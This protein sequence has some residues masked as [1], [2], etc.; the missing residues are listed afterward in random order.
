MK[1]SDVC[2]EYGLLNLREGVVRI[3]FLVKGAL[4]VPPEISL[5]KVRE[6][7]Q[8]VD[9]GTGY[10]KVPGAQIVREPLIDRQTM[11]YSG[12]YLYQVMPGISAPAL[13]ETD[14]DKLANGLYNLKVV[15]ILQYLATIISPLVEETEPVSR[16]WEIYRLTSE[17]PDTFL[18]GWQHS[19]FHLSAPQ[20]A[21]QMIDRE[22]SLGGITGGAFLDGWVDISAQVLPGETALLSPRTVANYTSHRPVI[23][24]MPTRQLHI[25]AGNAPEV[26]LASLLRALLTKSAAVIKLPFGAIIPGALFS[27]AAAAAAPGHPLTQNLSLVY[28][29]GGDRTIEDGLFHRDSFDRIVVWGSPEAV[30][31]VQSRALFTR[32]VVFN[33]RY[34]VSLIGRPASDDDLAEVVLKAAVD[35]LIYDQKACT[36]SLVH[37]VEGDLTRVRDYAVRM[38]Q[39]LALWDEHHPHFITPLKL[40]QIRSLKRGKYLNA[41]WYLNEKEGR[42]TSGV[43]V[44]DGEFDLLDHPM[45]RLVV[46]RPVARLEDALEYLNLNVAA[47]GIYPEEQRLLLRDRIAARG[48]SGILPLGECERMYP[49]MPHDGMPVLSELVEWKNA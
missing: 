9:A 10:V 37:Y 33:P 45:S 30:V 31:S 16:I 40:G 41:E 2:L 25:T 5:Q 38:Q 19:L 42:F 32:T 1:I 23:R 11:R 39:A 34:G 3:P 44:V 7:F 43:V 35:T 27:L 22:L 46:V 17:F 18:D 28:W 29:Q 15:D 26:P 47:V 8:N 49:G 12:D 20:A 24:A 6:A 21:R 4:V 14:I 36:A 48:V 13:L